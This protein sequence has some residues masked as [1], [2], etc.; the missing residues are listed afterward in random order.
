MSAAALAHYS[1][2][3]AQAVALPAFQGSSL[4][5]AL[6]AVRDLNQTVRN[7]NL[8]RPVGR[9]VDGVEFV[10]P[11]EVWDEVLSVLGTLEAYSGATVREDA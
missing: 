10:L 8:S 6:A 5:I 11:V 2:M 9:K 3:A 1:A 4:R 7:A